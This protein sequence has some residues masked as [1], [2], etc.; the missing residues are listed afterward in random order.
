MLEVPLVS[1]SKWQ[2]VSPRLKNMYVAF[3]D[4]NTGLQER[5][6]QVDLIVDLTGWGPADA[7]PPASLSRPPCRASSSSEPLSMLVTLCLRLGDDLRDGAAAARATSSTSSSRATYRST[8]GAEAPGARPARDERL[9]VGP[10]HP[11]DRAGS[12][13]TATSAARTGASSRSRRSSA[14][15]VH[16]TFELVFLGLLIARARSGSRSGRSRPSAAT[17]AEDYAAR[18]IGLRRHLDPELLRSRR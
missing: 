6:H 13:C 7:G 8:P 18:G 4:F 10:V 9:V 14:T 3:T 1:V 17:S 2:V 15:R 12:S 16:I 11:L 5:L